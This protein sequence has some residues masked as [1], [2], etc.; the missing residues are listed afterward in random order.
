[1][2]VEEAGACFVACCRRWPAQD[3]HHRVLVCGWQPKSRAA[4]Q[5]LLTHFCSLQLAAFSFRVRRK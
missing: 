4:S 2:L 5:V 1:M 3:V